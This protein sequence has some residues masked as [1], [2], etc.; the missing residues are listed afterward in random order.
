MIRDIVVQLNGGDADKTRLAQADGL[1]GLFEA[2]VTGAFLNVVPDYATLIDGGVAAPGIRRES[3]TIA[4]EFGDAAEAR[5]KSELSH[6]KAPAMLRRYDVPRRELARVAAEAA[7]AAD[8]FVLSRPYDSGDDSA[9]DT[10][11]AALFEGGRSVCVVPPGASTI[12]AIDTV[13]VGWSNTRECGRAVAEAMPILRQA[14]TVVLASVARH[15]ERDAELKAAADDMVRHLGHHGVPVEFRFLE[16]KDDV[17][18]TL[19]REAQAIGA[20]L[21]VT[22]AYG[23]SRLREAVVGGVTRDLLRKCPLPLLMAH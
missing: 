7:R 8:V 15:G 23:H 3:E 21:I 9:A 1:A 4:H 10:A 13:L 11:E 14:K 20:Q 22:G 12:G 18:D 2:H 19:V 16:R 6:L 5:L 17:A